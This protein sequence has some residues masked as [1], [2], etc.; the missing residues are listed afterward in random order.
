MG[1][2]LRVLKASLGE[3]TAVQLTVPEVRI[4]AAAQTATSALVQGAAS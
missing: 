1:N 2:F 4:P 3:P